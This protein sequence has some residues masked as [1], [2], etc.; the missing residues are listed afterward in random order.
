MHRVGL[1]QLLIGLAAVIAIFG[2][3]R[4]PSRSPTSSQDTRKA[5]VVWFVLMVCGISVWLL[6][7][8]HR[9]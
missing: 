5:L 9:L 1:P 7:T 4:L 8:F 2:A 3:S 6:V